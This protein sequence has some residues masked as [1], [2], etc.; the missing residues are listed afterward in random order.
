[1]AALRRQLSR[2]LQDVEDQ[3]RI[4]QRQATE[5]DLREAKLLSTVEEQSS[6]IDRL[7]SH[8]ASLIAKDRAID[9]ERLA[10]LNDVDVVR[11]EM[12]A[13]TSELRQSLSNL[14]QKYD[15]S[16]TTNR[17]TLHRIELAQFAQETK[18]RQVA[19]L[20]QQIISMQELLKQRT[21]Q[22]SDEQQRRD[23]AEQA[24]E[25]ARSAIPSEPSQSDIIKDELHRQVAHLRSLEL[26]NAK[27]RRRNETYERQHANVDVL[28]ESNRTLEKKLKVLDELRTAYAE[29]QVLI[30]R[31]EMEKAEWTV[32]LKNQP[33]ASLSSPRDVTKSLVSLQLENA[34]QKD[35][36][37][38]HA[39]ELARRDQLVAEAEEQLTQLQVVVRS[40]QSKLE[41][42]QDKAARSDKQADLLRKEVEMLRRHLESYSSEEAIHHTN[43]DVQKTARIAE[44]EELLEAHKNELAEVTKQ[45]KHLEGLVERYG[46]STTEI[47][48]EDTESHKESVAQQLRLNAELRH[49]IEELR[50]ANASLETEID[51][52]DAQ[53]MMQEQDHG[54]RGAYNPATTRVLEFRDSPDRV[55]HAVRTSTLERLRQENDA[56]LR[57]LVELESSHG[58]RSQ[59]AS[60]VPRASLDSVQAELVAAR[61]AVVQKET[62][63]RRISQAVAEKTESMR[64]A[65]SQLLGYQL[66]F[67]ESGRIRVTSVY[68]PSKDRSLAFDPW[69]GG[70]M[71][72]KL[73]SAADDQV[74]KSADARQSVQFWLES[75]ASLP[76]FLASLTMTLYEETTRGAARGVVV[77]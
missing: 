23:A 43:F 66:S 47:M 8:R 51:A 49:E 70:S 27:L 72:Y 42:A 36:L 50:L 4:R 12:L 74:L 71:P 24:L 37:V 19:E 6:K 20:E 68:A 60:L 45:A 11:A 10:A 21:D 46:G 32:F 15:E 76:G 64:I 2:A 63:L 22:L 13:Q 25:E 57:R 55:E 69:P 52:L 62:M 65:I 31:L 58:Q 9:H 77:G 44:L 29:Q 28:K 30:K 54:I 56:L 18:A 7:E 5:H 3:K 35:T 26:E 16:Q 1:M 59:A 73:V 41:R 33:E 38:K 40:Q 61:A 75:R 48:E 53:L 14:Q 67:L 34:L 39:G 17:E